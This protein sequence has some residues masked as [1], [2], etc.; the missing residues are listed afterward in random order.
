MATIHVLHPEH[1]PAARLAALDLPA[2]ARLAVPARFF[3]ANPGGGPAPLGLGRAV[4]DFIRWE[5]RSGRLADV[6]GSAWWRAVNGCMTLDLRTAGRALARG[7]R[8][9]GSDAIDAWIEYGEAD[10]DDAQRLLWRAHQ[11]SLARGLALAAPLLA[12]EPR[13][14]RELAATVVHNVG[15]AAAANVPT[16][17]GTLARLTRRHYP[18]HYPNRSDG[19][20][21]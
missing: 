6:G 3:T 11:A 19:F 5:H 21:R 18:A 17:D 15:R 10:P 4:L 14:E 20:V 16:G 13:A 8:A 1:G 12:L 7:E 9:P 2:S